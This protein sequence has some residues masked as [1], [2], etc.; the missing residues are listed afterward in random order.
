M[1]L[2]NKKVVVFGLGSSGFGACSLLSKAGAVVSATDNS[3]TQEIIEKSEVLKKSFFDVEIGRHSEALLK[4]AD[5]A[6]ASPGINNDALPIRFAIHANIPVISELELGFQ[7]CKAPIIAVTGTNGKSTVVTLLGHIFKKYGKKTIVCGNIGYPLSEAALQAEKGSVCICEVSSYQLERV[8]DFKPRVSCILNLSP[9]HLDRHGNMRDYL[10]CKYKIFKMQGAGDIAV[11]N[12]DDPRLRKVK[13]PRGVKQ[14]YYSKKCKVKGVYCR[15][16]WIINNLREKPINLFKLTDMQLIGPHNSE[17]MLAVIAISLVWGISARTIKDALFE[18]VPLPHRMETIDEI[19]D[20]VFINDSKA[21]N[22][23]AT[24][25]ALE[26]VAKRIILIA[27]GKDKGGDYC[28]IKNRVRSKVKKIFLIG[29]SAE[30][31]HNALGNFAST[32]IAG[33]LE[34]ATF[35]AFQCAEPGDAVL[36]SPMCS[37]FDMFRDFKHRGLVFR[38]A[39]SSVK[40]QVARG[41]K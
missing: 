17:N 14:L 30:L 38:R 40:S 20:V 1:N 37:S 39:V 32:E 16:G 8:L 18:Y 23:D 3:K 10:A 34:E 12:Y 35:K 2:R 7:F 25:R 29:E 28:V 33:S 27:G 26:T 15:N 41:K 6:V 13:L 11:L 36:L 21:T 24:N 22:V 9:D 31:I 4:G 5:M 19:G